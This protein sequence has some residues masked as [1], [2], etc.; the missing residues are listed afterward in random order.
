M[1]D[2]SLATGLRK[3]N[4]IGLRW[5]NVDLV[6]RHAFVSASQSKTRTAIPVP[7]NAE[8]AAII[9]RQIGKH[10]EFVFTYEG[11]PVKQCNTAAWRKAL[12]RAKIE[13]CLTSYMGILACSKWN[14]LTRIANIRRVVIF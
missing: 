8:A 14:I 3:A 6:R 12:K 7:L 2:F 9:A 5:K 1:A 4:V 11:N 10:I 13:A